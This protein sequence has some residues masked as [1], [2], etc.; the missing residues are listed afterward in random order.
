MNISEI[1]KINMFDRYVMRGG[2]DTLDNIQELCLEVI[3]MMGMDISTDSD[4]FNDIV[5]D[6]I[7][8]SIPNTHRRLK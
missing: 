6:V 3:T 8:K 1:Q 5:T 7:K 4:I 2:L